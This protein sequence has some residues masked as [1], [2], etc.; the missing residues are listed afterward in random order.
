[1]NKRRA[2]QPGSAL[3]LERI[4]KNGRHFPAVDSRHIETD[5]SRI[6]VDVRRIHS[7]ARDLLQSVYEGLCVFG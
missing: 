4:V 2:V 1:M 3:N 5:D 7:D 6:A